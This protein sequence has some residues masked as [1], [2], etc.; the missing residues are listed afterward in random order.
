MSKQNTDELYTMETGELHL[1][2]A[3]EDTTTQNVKTVIDYSTQTR[4]LIRQAEKS[5]KELKGMIHT[6]DAEMQDMKK[7]ISLLQAALYTGGTV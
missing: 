6:R 7:Q 1:R 5:I 2:K 4:D 3:F